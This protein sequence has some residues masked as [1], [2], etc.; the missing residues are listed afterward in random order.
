MRHLACLAALSISLGIVTGCSIPTRGPAV[1]P[2]YAERALPLG[3]PNA[4]FYAD[5]DPAPMVAEA[6]LAIE[7]E[8]A[9]LRAAGRPT[10][11]MPPAY[12]LAV[13]G[14]GDNG[15]F[16]AGLLNGWTTT[17]TARNSGW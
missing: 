2:S 4:R 16:G 12:F 11:P 13:S 14:G 9:T 5:G 6:A 15:A 3:I 8:Q 1:P 17:G 10:N 7:R